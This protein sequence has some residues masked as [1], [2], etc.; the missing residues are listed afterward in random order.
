MRLLDLVREALAL[1]ST[2]PLRDEDGPGTLADWDS[3][4][5]LKLLTAIE[6]NYHVTFDPDERSRAAS[7]GDLKALLREKGVPD[8]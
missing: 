5:H 7:L 6:K 8:P 4:A 3:L 2:A 1:E